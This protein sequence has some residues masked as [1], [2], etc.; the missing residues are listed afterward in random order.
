MS[1]GAQSLD[2]VQLHEI[3]Q[4]S[5]ATVPTQT[6]NERCEILDRK[7]NLLCRSEKTFQLTQC[8]EDVQPFHENDEDVS[9]TVMQVSS[10]EEDSDLDFI[11][12]FA[13]NSDGEEVEL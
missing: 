6:A 11:R 5:V 10:D 4:R 8:E 3:S 13:W 12:A 9:E 1:V 7:R 2:Q